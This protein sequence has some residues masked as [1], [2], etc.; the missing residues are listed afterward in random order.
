LPVET[1]RDLFN[2]LLD[3]LAKGELPAE[4]RLELSEAIGST[5]STELRSKLDRIDAELTPDTTLAGYAGLLFGGDSRKGRTILFSNQTAQC[6]RC[7]SIDDYG[8]NVAPSLNGVASRNTRE[9]LLESLIEPSARIAP[10]YGF[11]T[12]ELEGGRQLTG[13]LQHE[14]DGSLT[15]KLGGQPDTVIGKQHVVKRTD[16]PSSMPSMKGLLSTR[17]IRDLV[18]YLATLKEYALSDRFGF[19]MLPSL[20]VRPP[21]QPGGFGIIFHDPFFWVVYQGPSGFH[22]QVGQNAAGR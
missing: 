10:G 20:A 7:H 21:K 17:E 14:T 2:G 1:S 13:I 6:M 4:I 12:L 22:G 5:G 8:A 19:G 9:Q 18:S 15:L 16:A 3:Q 11:T